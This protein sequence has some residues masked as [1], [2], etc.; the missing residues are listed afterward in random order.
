MTLE[1]STEKIYILYGRPGSG[2]SNLMGYMIR[3]FKSR[4]LIDDCI[5]LSGTSFNGFFQ[6]ILPERNVIPYQTAGLTKILDFA[7]RRRLSGQTCHLLLIL[8]DIAGNNFYAPTFVKLINNFRHYNI[9][10]VIASQYPCLL[11]PNLRMNCHLAFVFG[12]R[13]KRDIEAL[14]QSYLMPFYEKIDKEVIGLLSGLEQYTCLVV[15]QSKTK[16]DE[17]LSLF[18]APLT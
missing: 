15:D 14:Y 16:K 8:D 11:Q 13:G 1:L 18:K 12:A 4:H 5:V 3:Y 10:I 9:T 2:K 7:A 6:R 17:A